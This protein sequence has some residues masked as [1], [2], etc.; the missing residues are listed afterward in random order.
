MIPQTARHLT[1]IMLMAG[2]ALCWSMGGI[3]L[4]NVHQADGWEMVFWR[5]LFMAT[6]LGVVL[7]VQHGR[8][9]PRRILAVGP[10]GL[11][12]GCALGATFFFYILS[13]ERTTVANTQIILSLVPV[14]AALF[15]LAVLRE[16]ITGRTWIAMAIAFA[17]VALMCWD[18]L[19]VAQGSGSSA[20]TAIGL[21]L[22]FGVP[23]CMAI[24]I[25]LLRRAGAAIDTTPT[26]L[27]AGLVSLAA[28]L[29]FALPLRASVSDLSFLALAGVFQ[30]GMGCVL[31]AYATRHLRAA[32]IGLLALLESVL[33]PLW[34]WLGIGERPTDLSIVGGMLV[35]GALAM[36]AALDLSRRRA[37]IEAQVALR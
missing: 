18:S 8:D 2:A 7:A 25:V 23:V 34:V 24:N 1:G 37:V 5:S 29:P 11:I 16:R 10:T 36:D 3:L 12:A 6:F 14:T 19:A 30:L 28:A 33:G 4:R 22:A 15:G 17:G 31:V 13:L 26:V 20:R 9:A 27:I 32:E 35:L 21:L